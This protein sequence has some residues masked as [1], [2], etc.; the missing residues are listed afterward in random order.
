MYIRLRLLPAGHVSILLHPYCTPGPSPCIYKRKGQGPRM[1][2][3]SCGTLSLS[4]VNAC[5]PYC[6]WIHSGAGQHEAAV[7]PPLC[8]ASRQ[9]IWAGA[10]SDNLLVG[11][12]TPRGW[13]ADRTRRAEHQRGRE[14]VAYQ[15][16]DI[17]ARADRRVRRCVGGGR[18]NATMSVMVVACY[19]LNSWAS[20]AEKWTRELGLAGFISGSRASSSRA[21]RFELDTTREL[22]STFKALTLYKYTDAISLGSIS[23]GSRLENPSFHFL[24]CS[25][26]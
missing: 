3:W 25:N 19:G 13:N 7:S 12:G 17:R 24:G 8:S 4:L 1:G 21:E 15:G 16:R 9:P 11:P 20:S 14:V 10:H 18:H 26:S 6:K 23:L 22:Q 5:N 2:G